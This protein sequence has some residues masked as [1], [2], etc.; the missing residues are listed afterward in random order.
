MALQVMGKGLDSSCIAPSLRRML[1]VRLVIIGTIVAIV[2]L[3][4]S[5]LFKALTLLT[6]VFYLT[7][8]IFTMDDIAQ[9]SVIPVSPSVTFLRWSETTSR[10]PTWTLPVVKLMTP[11]FVIMVECRVNH[12]CCVQHC[13]EALHMGINFF[14]VLWQVGGELID[15]HP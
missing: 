11:C 13:L 14:V 12:G 1:S 4:T 2:P 6:L 9:V 10:V 15:K 7:A 3:F 5:L 8:C